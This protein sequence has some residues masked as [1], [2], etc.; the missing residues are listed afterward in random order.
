M[1]P[2]ALTIAGVD[3]SG[4]AGIAAD[5]KTFHQHQVYGASVI[6]LL[7]VQNTQGVTAIQLVP[8]EF[9]DRQIDAVVSDLPVRAAKT[10][11]M[12]SHEMIEAL[13]RKARH[14][15]FPL[16]VDPVM[17]SK[18]GHRLLDA[19]AESTLA[20]QLIPMA[21]LVTPNRPEAEALTGRSIASMNDVR[22]VAS[23]IVDLGARAVLIKGGHF[24]NRDEAVDVLYYDNRFI[25]F[26]AKRSDA[27]HTHGTGCT[28][29]AAIVAWLAIGVDLPVAVERAKHWLTRAI[30]SAQ[31]LGHGIGPVNHLEPLSDW[32]ASAMTK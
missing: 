13:A 28:L 27:A 24:D 14:F 26:R 5:L 18:H 11:A 29:S 12:G 32:S 23:R 25:E 10:G 1:Q 15:T 8:T 6:T 30:N 7:T 2:V 4:G 20:R 17:V 31:P 21:F 16:V 22:E 9:V 3:P 19:E